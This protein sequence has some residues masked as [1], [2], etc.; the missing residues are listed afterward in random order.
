MRLC[1]AG[2]DLGAERDAKVLLEQCRCV[3]HTRR[4]SCTILTAFR[5]HCVP[6][7][8][9]HSHLGRHR[10]VGDKGSAIGR[11]CVGNVVT[12]QGKG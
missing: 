2:G 5:K 1:R 10:L 8:V 4:P 7:L 11:A 12:K 3:L 9:L 6:C